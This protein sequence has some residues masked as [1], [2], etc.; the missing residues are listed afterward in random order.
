MCVPLGG[1]K[2]LQG[3]NSITKKIYEY[4]SDDKI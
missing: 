1:Q 4:S 3:Q 2:C